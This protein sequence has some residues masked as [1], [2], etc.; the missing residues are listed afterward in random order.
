MRLRA[1]SPE[2]AGIRPEAVEQF[3]KKGQAWTAAGSQ[4]PALVLVA[5]RRGIIFFHEAFGR[6]GPG[7][8]SPKLAKNALFP[9][10]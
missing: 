7:E 10:A 9:L 4:T 3:R 1:G 8:D 2:E 5:A 6:R